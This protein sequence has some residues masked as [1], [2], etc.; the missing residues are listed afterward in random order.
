MHQKLILP[1]ATTHADSNY[2][3]PQTE[4]KKGFYEVFASIVLSSTVVAIV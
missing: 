2:T 4:L 3:L 1:F